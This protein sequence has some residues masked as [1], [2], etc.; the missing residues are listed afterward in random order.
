MD[1]I[2]VII[3]RGL[4]LLRDK[5]IFLSKAVSPNL[6]VTALEAAHMTS[7]FNWDDMLRILVPESISLAYNRY[8]NW[9]IRHSHHGLSR[10]GR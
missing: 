8:K 4:S 5:Y 2:T 9:Y 7:P 3:E 1:N 6:D 10:R